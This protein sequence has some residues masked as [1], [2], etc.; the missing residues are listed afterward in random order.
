VATI[1]CQNFCL[2]GEHQPIESLVTGYWDEFN[3]FSQ[4]AKNIASHV[5]PVVGRTLRITH[6]SIANAHNLLPKA[7]QNFRF[8]GYPNFAI[9][10][11]LYPPFDISM[12]VRLDPSKVNSDALNFFN[13]VRKLQNSLSQETIA[14]FEI[15]ESHATLHILNL[16]ISDP[17][18]S[19]VA[20]RIYALADNITAS[21]IIES[22]IS[23]R[24]FA[25]EIS[26]GRIATDCVV[27]YASHTPPLINRAQAYHDH[28]ADPANTHKGIGGTWLPGGILAVAEGRW[29]WDIAFPFNNQN[30]R[31][32]SLININQSVQ[33]HLLSSTTSGQPMEIECVPGRNTVQPPLCPQPNQELAA[34]SWSTL[35]GEL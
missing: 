9:S 33:L 26:S 20:M 7:M 16:K 31:Q 18:H 12:A 4:K 27:P 14:I 30:E 32:N 8:N 21:A 6:K 3:Y 5:T 11:A 1:F 15:S 13:T 19:R 22:I 23:G 24:C 29:V 35:L 2:P 10:D 17:K 34:Q 28:L 25:S